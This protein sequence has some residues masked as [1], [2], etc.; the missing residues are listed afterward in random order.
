MNLL[1]SSFLKLQCV[2]MICIEISFPNQS[3]LKYKKITFFFFLIQIVKIWGISQSNSK[4]K[5]LGER[6]VYSSIKQRV[7]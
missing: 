1:L 2:K 7:I 5:A 4:V 3:K 6:K